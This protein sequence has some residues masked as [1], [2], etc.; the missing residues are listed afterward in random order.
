MAWHHPVVDLT[1]AHVDAHHLGDLAA[2]V[3]AS[4]AGHARAAAVAQTGDELATQLTAWLGIDGGVDGFVRNLLAGVVGPHALQG[5]GDL[6]RRPL[7]L[8]QGE[9]A[10]T[11][12]EGA[13]WD[14]GA[15]LHVGS[16]RV[17]TTWWNRI[18][19]RS[20]AL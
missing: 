14:T 3:S 18:T 2:P 9:Y 19:E 20:S 11:R 6:L 15:Q 1:Q 12:F 7:P 13:A 17:G 10:T 8:Q 16:C 5:T 4:L